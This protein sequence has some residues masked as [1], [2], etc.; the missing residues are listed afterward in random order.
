MIP[1]LSSSSSNQLIAS[2]ASL[3][4]LQARELLGSHPQ[5][6]SQHCAKWAAERAG[7][8]VLQLKIQRAT[9]RTRVSVVRVPL[10]GRP[11]ADLEI[12]TRESPLSL[13]SWAMGPS[14]VMTAT[15]FATV[16]CRVRVVPLTSNVPA[17]P[18]RPSHSSNFASFSASVSLLGSFGGG[19]ALRGWFPP[20]T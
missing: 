1:A 5:S 6:L 14:V 20:L 3:R 16:G 13:N 7:D 10:A 9:Y 4:R 17:C 12:S 15:F 19:D 8:P 11:A 18:V 2:I